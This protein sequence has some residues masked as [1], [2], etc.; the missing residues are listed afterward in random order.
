[1]HIEVGADRFLALQWANY[2]FDLFQRHYDE[3]T[4][5][6]L[7]KDYLNQQ[8]DGKESSRKTGNQL[9]RL[10]LIQDDHQ[11]LRDKALQIPFPIKPDLM[12]FLHLGIAVNE[13][14]IFNETARAISLLSNLSS[15]IPKQSVVSRVMET[16]ANPTSI[17]RS[18]SRVFQTLADWKLIKVDKKEL[19]VEQIT[20]DDPSLASWFILALMKVNRI[21][22]LPLSNVERVPQLIGSRFSDTRMLI[23]KGIF[24]KIVRNSQGMEVIKLI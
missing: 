16:F 1:M 15:S 7:L 10:W 11:D 17:P 2:S 12:A 14:P 18:T 4:L 19:I 8:I 6:Q 5:Y 21:Q 23:D 9:K 13:F 24:L 3:L 22:E 20:L